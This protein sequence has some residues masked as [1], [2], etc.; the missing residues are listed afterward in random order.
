MTKQQLLKKIDKVS[1]A[2]AKARKEGDLNKAEAFALEKQFLFSKYR[3]MAQT[4]LPF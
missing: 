4:G 3:E 2:E 1:Q